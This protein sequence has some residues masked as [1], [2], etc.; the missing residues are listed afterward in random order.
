[1]VTVVVMT[2]GV[3]QF[4]AEWQCKHR[5]TTLHRGESLGELFY[6]ILYLFVSADK[7]LK[8]INWTIYYNVWMPEAF[9]VIE[10]HVRPLGK[11]KK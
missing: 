6:W 1:M 11:N 4:W 2:K 3:Y 10:L 8:I 9:F 7:I 5:F